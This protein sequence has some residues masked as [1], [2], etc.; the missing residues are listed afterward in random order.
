[1]TCISWK[2]HIDAGSVPFKRLFERYKCPNVGT[3]PPRMGRRSPENELSERSAYAT[4]D[5]RGGNG[6]SNLF[7]LRLMRLEQMSLRDLG[8]V[9]VI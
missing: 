5:G 7:E 9:P 2:L 3:F 1:M 4:L 8:T 6:P